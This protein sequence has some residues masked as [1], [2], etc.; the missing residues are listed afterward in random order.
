[1]AKRLMP[2]AF[3]GALALAVSMPTLLTS[4][5][6]YAQ[7]N[8]IISTLSGAGSTLDGYSGDGG[9]AILARLT[10][11]GGLALG[12]RNSLYISDTG[13][14][15]VRAIDSSGRIRT[16]AGIG[17][18][19]FGGDGGPATQ[20][21]L[22]FPRGIAF[23]PDGNLYIADTQ[24]HRI[25]RVKQNGIIETFAGTGERGHEGDGGSAIEAKLSWPDCLVFD[26]G[27]VLYFTESLN[28]T[29]RRITPEGVIST[30]VGAP[31]RRGILASPR[32]IALGPSDVLYVADRDHHRISKIN[33]E[34]TVTT[35]AG[36]GVNHGVS[37]TGDGGPATSASIP[38]PM[39]VAFDPAGNLVIASDRIRRVDKNG[40]V[41]TLIG[42]KLGEPEGNDGDPLQ[43]RLGSPEE[44]I[45]DD[46]GAL[47]VADTFR[48]R[49]LRLDPDGK[50]NVV[51]GLTR[52]PDEIDGGPAEFARH[53]NPWGVAVSSKGDVFVADTGMNR[54]CR[55]TPDGRF[56]K[57]AGKGQPIIR[58]EGSGPPAQFSGDGRPATLA[59]LDMPI[60]V[61]VDNKGNIYI[62]DS[63]NNRVRRVS[64]DGIIWTIAGNGENGFGGDGGPATT[65]KLSHPM[66]VAVDSRGNVYI[67]DRQNNRIRRVTPD[68]RIDTV[69][70][71]GEKGDNDDGPALSIKLNFPHGVAVDRQDILYVADTFNHRVRKLGRDGIVRSIAGTGKQEFTGDGGPATNAGLAAPD[72]IA[73]DAQGDIYVADR[74][75]WRV[76]KIT[77]DGIIH[78]IAGN[79]ESGFSRDGG[80]ALK[81]PIFPTSVAVDSRGVVY[82]T[83]G[84]RIR[85]LTPA[86]PR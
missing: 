9:P 4:F 78:T 57:V 37:G 75:N 77:N 5:R 24:N 34:G 85:V 58:M 47:Y 29:I 80:P 52:L 6:V 62:A 40:V 32:G 72:S 45:Y 67:A 28:N 36:D 82:V 27:G 38:Y 22:L 17:D 2:G 66:G 3:S 31:G 43:T 26:H 68:G 69:I 44:L 14:H 8:Y 18:Q 30:V 55:I 51:A 65:A 71:S 60:G 15:V 53:F 49:V 61:A 73:I 83:H 7:Q 42:V 39:A 50:L 13:N 20:A 64:P 12:P 10:K 79:H 56:Y 81:A 76:R 11:P 84:S 63:Y 48:N 1:M 19:G 16:V 35:V 54:I 74:A 46:A 33:T 21:K 25:R 86:Q 41:T 70:G 23:D 59:D